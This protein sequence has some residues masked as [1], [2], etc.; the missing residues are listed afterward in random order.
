[1]GQCDQL[2][3]VNVSGTWRVA[4]ETDEICTCCDRGID[5]MWTGESTDL[6]FGRHCHSESL[7]RQAI[8]G[9]AVSGEVE[10]AGV[11]GP[12]E[13]KAICTEGRGGRFARLCRQNVCQ[14]IWLLT[15]EADVD[16][17]THDVSNHVVQERIGFK[18]ETHIRTLHPHGDRRERF[19]RGVRLALRRS[20]GAEIVRS[21]EAGGS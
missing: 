18:V 12:E 8:E 16:Q 20:K 13:I 15:A 6:N 14:P 7:N 3:V 19:D 17:T 11:G 1:M 9:I 4:N 10:A 5:I 2:G 21:G